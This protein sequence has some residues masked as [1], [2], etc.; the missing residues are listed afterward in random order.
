MARNRRVFGESIIN[1]AV[2]IVLY[3]VFSRFTHEQVF[4]A[5]QLPEIKRIPLEAL[6]LQIQIQE[7]MGGIDVP[8]PL[9]L[10]A[11]P[12]CGLLERA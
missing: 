5:Q 6:C 9:L 8:R 1:D 11:L 10:E 2:S 12:P 3:R 4:M 7:L